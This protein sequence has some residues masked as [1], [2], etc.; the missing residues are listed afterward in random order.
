LPDVS[1]SKPGACS[2]NFRSTMFGKRKERWVLTPPK[3]PPSSP[4]GPPFSLDG[5]SSLLGGPSSPW[6]DPPSLQG[7]RPPPQ[8]GLPPTSP[9]LLQSLQSCPTSLPSTESTLATLIT[10]SPMTDPRAPSE[11]DEK[12]SVSQ[13]VRRK[14]NLFLPDESQGP[15]NS[16]MTPSFILLTPSLQSTSPSASSS[17]PTKPLLYND[18]HDK[19][20]P[21]TAP[22]NRE[23][24]MTQQSEERVVAQPE[25]SFSTTW[26]LK[27][28]HRRAEPRNHL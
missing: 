7:S 4:S 26:L 2:P 3:R 9:S 13:N 8:N 5:R 1:D 19:Q 11:N 22:E 28:Y 6:G 17:L 14:L 16:S 12:S 15:S 27:R 10:V 24:V 23:G 18:K 21:A 25:V 20:T